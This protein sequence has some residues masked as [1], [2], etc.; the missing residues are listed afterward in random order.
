MKYTCMSLRSGKN[1]KDK[2]L[3]PRVPDAQLQVDMKIQAN[4]NSVNNQINF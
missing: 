2:L 3:I 4:R 1:I